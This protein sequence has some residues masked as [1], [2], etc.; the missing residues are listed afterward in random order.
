M[1][2]KPERPQKNRSVA[3]GDPYSVVRLPE[4]PRSPES[5]RL[6][7]SWS[8][9]DYLYRIAKLFAEFE[10]TENPLG[11]AFALINPT[12]PL[13]S[14]IIIDEVGDHANIRTWTVGDLA[15]QEFAPAKAHAAAV[16]SY[17]VGSTPTVDTPVS[18]SNTKFIVIPLA[19]DHLP[20][21]GALQLECLT[22]CNEADVAFANAVGNHL[23]I[24]LHRAKA[25][26]KEVTARAQAEAGEERM[27]FLAAASELLSVSLDYRSTWEHVARLATRHIADFCC[28]EIVESGKPMQRIAVCSPDLEEAITAT[29]QIGFIENIISGVIQS[30]QPALSPGRLETV[31]PLPAVESKV[32]IKSYACAPLRLSNNTLGAIML[33]RVRNAPQ[34]TGSDL[35]LLEDL[36]RRVAA[37]FENARHYAHA[38]LAIRSRDDVLAAVSHDLKGPLTIILGFATHFLKAPKV[39]DSLICDRRQVETIQRSA[40]YMKALIDDLLDTASIEAQRLRVNRELCSIESVISEALELTQRLQKDDAPL[41]RSEVAPRISPVF[42]DRHRILQVFANLVGNAMKFTP[43]GGT[44]T[45]RADEVDGELR[46]SVKDSGAGIPSDEIPYLFD[47]FWQG[48]N[49]AQQGTG[50][51]LFVVQ[52]IIESHGGKIWVNS[53]LGVGSEFCFTLPVNPP[54]R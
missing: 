44:I 31:E 17:F 4:G 23:A 46:C 32:D 29:Q 47:R 20:V 52:G 7:A 19:V 36:A 38:L 54:N 10:S 45:V 51:G 30:G 6:I 22:P 40:N 39:T 24:A 26:R 53:K 41:I 9:L 16:Y 14:A 25:H 50:L 8:R 13:R 34:Y 43:A 33:V 37:A 28:I 49:N 15:D 1:T 48:Q 12:L 42:V 2:S 35:V 21:F 27:R 18:A 3:I 11:E 5:R